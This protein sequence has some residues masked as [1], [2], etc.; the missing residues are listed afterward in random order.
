M[1]K[2]FAFLLIVGLLFLP[3]TVWSGEKPD[4]YEATIKLFKDSPVVKPFFEKA[5]GYAVLPV[6]GKGGAFVGASFGKGKVYRSS[7]PI[8]KVSMA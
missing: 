7:K 3:V 8:G 6:V 4:Q 5:Y 2:N 1:K